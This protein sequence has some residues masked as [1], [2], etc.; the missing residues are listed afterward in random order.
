MFFCPKCNNILDIKKLLSDQHQKGG[1]DVF[2]N[3]ITSILNNKTIKYDDI[4]NIS[5]QK[6]YKHPTYKKL[7]SHEKTKIYNTI[8]DLLPKKQKKR[9]LKKA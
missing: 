4:K 5:T 9:F 2:E 7:K 1:V 6:L 3:I 8:Q